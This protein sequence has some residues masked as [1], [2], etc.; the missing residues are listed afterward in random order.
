MAPIRQRGTTS[1]SPGLTNYTVDHP[2]YVKDRVN[3]PS[4]GF[5]SIGGSSN[6]SSHTPVADFQPPYFPP[7]YNTSLHHNHQFDLQAAA[8]AVTSGNVQ[9]EYGSSPFNTNH[10]QHHSYNNDRHSLLRSTGVSSGNDSLQMS[11]PTFGQYDSRAY[12]EYASYYSRHAMAIDSESLQLYRNGLLASDNTSSFRVPGLEEVPNPLTEHYM[13]TFQRD[14]R[15]PDTKDGIALTISGNVAPSD[16]FCNVPGRLSL[17]SS[18]SKYKV[19]VAEVQRRL[20]PPECLNASLLGG[21]LRRA[22]SKNGGRILRE[23]L[24]KIGVNLPAGRRKA[25]TVTLLT[26]LV[27]GESTHLARDFHYVCDQEFPARQ[28]AEHNIRHHNHDSSEISKRKAMVLASR[29]LVKE[30]TE[31]LSQDRSPL[32]NCRLSPVL[33]PSMQRHLTHFSLITHGFGSPAIVGAMTAFQNYMTEMVKFYDKSYTNNN[34]NNGIGH[35]QNEIN[36]TKMDKKDD[37]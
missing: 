10:H 17:L 2:Y 6:R 29:Q 26:S 16:I 9:L 1:T 31:L 36:I 3:H 32:G 21:I 20:S 14:F 27:E 18:N 15:R 11:A 22:K 12:A 25:A 7:P 30:F 13:A 8:A 5:G 34:H 19:T 35:V 28:C 4:S 24:E 23:K 37:R 33:E